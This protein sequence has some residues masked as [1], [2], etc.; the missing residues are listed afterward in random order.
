MKVRNVLFATALV[1]STAFITAQVASQ[2][3][4][5]AGQPPQ[6]SAEEI[7]WMESAKVGPNHK[8]LEPLVGTFKAE[9]KFWMGGPE[10]EPMISTGVSVNKWV[11]DGRFVQSEFTGSFE[12]EPFIGI[13]YTGYDNIQ[14]KYIGSWID[15]MM[16]GMLT[17]TGTADATGK[18]LTMTGS[19]QK[20]TGETIKDRNV[21]R[22]IDNNKHI[23]ELHHT[24]PGKEE[25]KVG[26]I[27][28]TRTK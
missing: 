11:L 22:I 26:E 23:F 21:T 5:K 27:T 28:Y 7:A 6:P 17:H 19:F 14:K 12:N 4:G 2:D 3:K 9:T 16:T 20:P 8:K 18:V 25:V 10:S 1:L 15:T 24:E 13:G